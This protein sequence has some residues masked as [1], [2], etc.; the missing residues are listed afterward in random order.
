MRVASIVMYLVSWYPGVTQGHM[1][2]FVI[3]QWQEVSEITWTSDSNRSQSYPTLICWA[4]KV[5]FVL[6]EFYVFKYRHV[7]CIMSINA[8]HSNSPS[9]GVK[10]VQF[11]I[12]SPEEI[13]S[14]IF[15]VCRVK[16]ERAS[17]HVLARSVN[18]ARVCCPWPEVVLMCARGCVSATCIKTHKCGN[19]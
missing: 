13:V 14:D 11:G 16:H 19:R 2:N 15:R 5:V 17:S 3:M 8:S 9:R 6:F 4:A 7:V 1:G 10:K 12:L 18:R